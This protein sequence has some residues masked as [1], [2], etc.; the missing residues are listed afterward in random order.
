MM[1]KMGWAEG[2]GLGK[3]S[4]GILTHVKLKKRVEEVGLGSEVE[5]ARNKNF[6]S[7]QFDYNDL[8]TELAGK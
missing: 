2:K 4:N 5:D 6:V 8:L 7:Q 1:E 3:S